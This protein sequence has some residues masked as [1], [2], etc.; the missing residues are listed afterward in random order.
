MLKKSAGSAPKEDF[1]SQIE[2]AHLVSLLSRQLQ[3]NNEKKRIK[4]GSSI[5]Q[6]HYI[7]YLSKFE[8]TDGQ[9]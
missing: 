4:N 5:S 9:T 7:K 1:S 2:K 6:I 3:M 8:Q